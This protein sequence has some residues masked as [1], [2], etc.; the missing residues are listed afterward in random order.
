MKVKATFEWDKTVKKKI[1]QMPDKFMYAIARTTLD[2]VG[3][4]QVTP[5]LTGLTERS[6]YSRGVQKDAD[7]Y[8]IGNFTDYAS[9]VYTKPQNTHWSR[10]GTKAQWFETVWQQKGEA[11]TNEQIARYKL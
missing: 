7:G 6:M 11:I 5:Y 2:Y 1:E 9:Y 10:P 4:A 8:Y 3:S